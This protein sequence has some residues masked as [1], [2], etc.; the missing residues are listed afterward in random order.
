MPCCPYPRS[1]QT[2]KSFG[3]SAR[4]VRT[5]NEHGRHQ[6]LLGFNLDYSEVNADCQLYI[7]ASPRLTTSAERLTPEILVRRGERFQGDLLNIFSHFSL[8]LWAIAYTSTFS[9]HI[10]F[11]VLYSFL[12]FCWLLRV[13]IFYL[14]HK[15]FVS[16]GI[17][18]LYS[19]VIPICDC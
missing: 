8:V 1:V 13:Y 6:M 5:M 2:V 4:L 9:L 14:V 18:Q 15:I 10:N 17:S 19:N 11:K 16:R 7:L 12:I 3:S